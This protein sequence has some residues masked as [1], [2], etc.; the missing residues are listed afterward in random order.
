MDL[1]ELGLRLFLALFL[2]ELVVIVILII[3]KAIKK[4]EIGN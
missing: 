2:L 4:G 3:R 1:L